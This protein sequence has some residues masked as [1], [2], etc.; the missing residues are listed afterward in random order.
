MQKL[1]LK[2]SHPHTGQEQQESPRNVTDPCCTAS[3]L[4]EVH[5]GPSLFF[6]GLSV[7][8]PHPPMASSHS[9]PCLCL[10]SR[11]GPRPAC[12]CSLHS[13]SPPATCL[14]RPRTSQ[15]AP[16]GPHTRPQLQTCQ[17]PTL[18][19]HTAAGR[20][21]PTGRQEQPDTRPKGA[22]ESPMRRA[23][24]AGFRAGIP[25]VSS[26]TDLNKTASSSLLFC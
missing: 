10:V 7:T 16:G 8:R 3:S 6:L 24:H 2:A 9:F 13:I 4:S 5:P 15:R 26:Q 21:S 17:R 19:S 22:C 23:P 12:P 14:A 25:A 18:A 1:S 20:A 11:P